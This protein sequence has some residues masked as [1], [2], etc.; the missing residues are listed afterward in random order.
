MTN[1]GPKNSENRVFGLLGVIAVE[2][3]LWTGLPVVATSWLVRKFEVSEW[4]ILPSAVV[5]LI[6]SIVR[7]VRLLDRVESQK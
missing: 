1:G 4:W 7:L 2:T 3:A 6:V 5:G